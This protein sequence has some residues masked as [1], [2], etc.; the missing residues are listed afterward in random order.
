M[1]FA[2]Y[3]FQQNLD[4]GC[5]MLF[6]NSKAGNSERL[7]CERRS[8]TRRLQ[9]DLLE[10]RRLLAGIELFVFDDA[11]QSRT[12]HSESGV[13]G[14][15]AFID[16]N[17]DSRHGFGEPLAV[18]NSEGI[19]SFSGI[20]PGVYSIRLLGSNKSIEQTT[21]ISNYTPSSGTPAQSQ[22][23]LLNCHLKNMFLKSKLIFHNQIH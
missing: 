21:P 4:V 15:V 14:Q 16:L 18:T 19:A 20:D 11:N 5:R 6:K 2:N 1:E 23:N 9:L 8:R 17:R 13:A 12:S 10:D 22:P 7:S 3:S